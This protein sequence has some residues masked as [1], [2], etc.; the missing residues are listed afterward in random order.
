LN[1]ENYSLLPYDYMEDVPPSLPESVYLDK[2]I[3]EP[4]TKRLKSLYENGDIDEYAALQI[5][6][7]RATI[8]DILTEEERYGKHKID[9]AG[10]IVFNP[11]RINV[12]SVA[13]IPNLHN[14][15]VVTT[16][17]QIY[18]VNTDLIDPYYF[19]TLLKTSTY[20]PT[21]NHYDIS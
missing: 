2:V 14:T 17:Y 1:W 3:S 12:G 10:D 13:T 18:H 4:K 21:I 20:K 6:Q 7:T 19:A 16:I 15:I 11:H 5:S 8:A 9:H